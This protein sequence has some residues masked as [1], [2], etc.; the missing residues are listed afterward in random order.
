MHIFLSYA[1]EDTPAVQNL[2]QRLEADGLRPW[3]EDQDLLPGQNRQYVVGKKI[4]EASA[5]VVCLSTK[6]VGAAGILHK[7]MKAAL[8]VADEQP[9][10]T[11]F[12]IPVKLDKCEVPDR[13]RHVH[14]VNL[15][16]D[17]ERVYK[18]LVRALH[19]RLSSQ[20]SA[21]STS[22]APQPGNAQPSGDTI[23]AQGSSGFVNRP[24]GPVYQHFGDVVGGNTFSGDVNIHTGH[25]ERQQGTA[26]TGSTDFLTSYEVAMHKLLERLGRNHPRYGEALVYEQR[27]YENIAATRR[28]KN[29][30]EREADRLEV[31][32]RLN[33]LALE[34]IGVSFN[35]LCREAG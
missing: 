6:A 9:E 25:G 4:R 14:P 23:N 17:E 12:V 29:T 30:S 24:G 19:Q 18:L 27:L 28:Y 15:F 5:C 10:G 13:L 32:D 34:T 21:S 2:Y 3:M 26:T 8:D 31:I 11:I 22:S 1:P 20:D 16:E 7:D 33:S 35:E